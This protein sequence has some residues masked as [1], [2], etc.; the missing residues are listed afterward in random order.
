MQVKLYKMVLRGIVI[1]FHIII[2]N[3][4]LLFLF[5]FLLLL[6]II[7]YYFYLFSYYYWK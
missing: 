2:G 3:K 4:S 1:Y 5:I 6:A 7:H